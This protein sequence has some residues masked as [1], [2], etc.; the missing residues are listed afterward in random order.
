MPNDTTTA[1][2][3][4]R[5]AHPGLPSTSSPRPSCFGNHSFAHVR[6]CQSQANR[7]Q[8]RQDLRSLVCRMLFKQPYH[9]LCTFKQTMDHVP[10]HQ[11]DM[12]P[13]ETRTTNEMCM[14]VQPP[15]VT[16]SLIPGH[17]LSKHSLGDEQPAVAASDTISALRGNSKSV[18]ILIQKQKGRNQQIKIRQPPQ[19]T[20]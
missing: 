17:A 10:H 4:L 12:Q 14:L 7:G 5:K 18:N 2:Q 6:Q 15:P 13:A 16:G 11:L 1:V 20:T 8:V 3:H 9:H 19:T